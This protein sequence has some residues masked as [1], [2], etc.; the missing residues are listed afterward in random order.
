MD[1]PIGVFD[2]GVGGLTVVRELLKLLSCENLVYFG[3]TARLPYGTKSPKAVTRFSLAN[4]RFLLSK[5]IK[6]LVVAC[7]TSSALSLAAIK[8]NFPIPAVGVITP[9]VEKALRITRN[10]SIGVIAT[11]ATIRSGAYQREIRARSKASRITANACPLFVPLVEEGW[12][13]DKITEDIVER[14]FEPLEKAGIDTL[15]LGCTHYPALKVLFSS[16]LG[17][18]VTI[19]DSAEEVAERVKNILCEGGILRKKRETGYRH[20]FVSDLYDK[21][22]KVGEVFLGERMKNVKEVNLE[23]YYA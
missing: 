2:S 8:R 16:V 10:H 1:R 5:K 15:I 6:I 3:D 20:Y 7:N 23:R 13:R 14:Y 18:S 21:F 19:V 22:I 4:T 12:H 11:E 17:N 9:G